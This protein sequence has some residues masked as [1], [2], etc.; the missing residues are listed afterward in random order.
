MDV[1][2]THF[3]F[4][5]SESLCHFFIRY[6]IWLLCVVAWCV[7]PWAVSLASLPCFTVLYFLCCFLICIPQV[8]TASSS[9]SLLQLSLLC[10]YL[11]NIPLDVNQCNLQQPVATQ[12]LLFFTNVPSPVS[13]SHL[14]LLL[15][16]TKITQQNCAPSSIN[17]FKIRVF[18]RTMSPVSLLKLCYPCC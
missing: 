10:H 16:L 6:L 8:I 1:P 17:I 9:M 11:T 14:Y 12:S 4:T 5:W 15:F 3:F 2:I 7:S 13:L 18:T